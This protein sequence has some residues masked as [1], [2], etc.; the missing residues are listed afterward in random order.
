MDNFLSLFVGL[1]GVINKDIYFWRRPQEAA[2]GNMGIRI[3][4]S[5]Q[6]Y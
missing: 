6:E 5:G 4:N 1:G 2:E 3:T